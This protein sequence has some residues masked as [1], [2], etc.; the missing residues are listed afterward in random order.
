MSMPSARAACPGPPCVQPAA[1]AS[2]QHTQPCTDPPSPST[3][4]T[5]RQKGAMLTVLGATLVTTIPVLM[6][7]L[8]LGS[9]GYALPPQTPMEPSFQPWNTGVR[10]ST[11][12]S[13]P[14]EA[15]KHI[16]SCLRDHF[17][18]CSWP[19][20]LPRGKFP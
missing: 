3:I 18:F 15:V 11:T 9:Y 13:C 16:P 20:P 10:V 1:A 8:Q 5:R 12:R 7:R 4:R 17:K 19:P 14:F 2:V 6:M